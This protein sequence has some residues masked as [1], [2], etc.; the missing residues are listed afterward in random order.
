MVDSRYVHKTEKSTVLVI[1]GGVAGIT[2]SLD[3]A[4]T[5]QVVHLVENGHHLGGQ[6]SK[7]DKL[8][9]TDHC[10]FC[11]LWTDVKK[12]TEH[13]LI[14]VHTL[15]H[16]KEL[17]KE[18]GRY[19]AVILKNPRYIDE[20]KCIFCGRCEKEC[21]AS[22][23]HPDWEHLSPPSFVIDDTTC[24]KCGDCVKV[25]PTEAI[26]LELKKE[27]I[28]LHISNVIWATGFKEADLNHL[29]EYG[30]GTHPDIMTS[31]K[32]EEWTAEAGTNRGNIIKRSDRAAPT[33]IAF[34]QCAG[35]RDL[36]MITSSTSVCCM[37]A[38]KQAGWVKKRNP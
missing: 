6:V 14:T 21:P 18:S 34:I 37:H 11:P 36:R 3:L 5:G 15:S 8:Y 19:S 12:C 25:C 35:A 24:T 30:S 4:N 20:K 9:P 33:N 28:N 29:K 13:P 22:A 7:L 32:F 17:K 16:V 1:G 27:E 2:T 23:I 31:M 38:F 26:N 10:A